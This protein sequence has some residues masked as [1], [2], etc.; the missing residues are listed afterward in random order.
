MEANVIVLRPLFLK[1]HGGSDRERVCWGW[2]R[3]LLESLV[4][5]LGSRWKCTKSRVFCGAPDEHL[6]SPREWSR[7][8]GQ[9]RWRVS[10][11]G[12]CSSRVSDDGRNCG[13]QGSRPFREDVDLGTPRGSWSETPWTWGRPGGRGRRP[14]RRRPVTEERP[15]GGTRHRHRQMSSSVLE[16]G[17]VKR[18]MGLVLHL[19]WTKH[20][21]GVV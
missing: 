20:R 15:E 19:Y 5:S 3:R 11:P 6:I 16:A 1:G 10:T 7:V 4:L 21:P 14:C 13:R 8:W 18:V 12:V 17:G 2:S 9:G